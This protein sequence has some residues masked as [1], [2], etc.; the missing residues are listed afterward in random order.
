MRG[1]ELHPLF[2]QDVLNRR[3]FL[4]GSGGALGYAA[5]ASLMQPQVARAAAVT[6]PAPAVF[7]N[8]AAKAKRIIYLFQ[9]GAPS[10]MDLF[11]PKPEMAKRRGEDLPESIRQGQRL[12]TM[13]SGQK[14]F[15]V[16]PS[17]FKFAQHGD[18]GMWF[19]DLVPNI[20]R[21][22]DRWCM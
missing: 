16:A 1:K 6:G 19:S 7:P 10:Q 15:P 21:H 13:T 4:G 5:L 18:S 3:V 20:A 14:S 2:L 12:T 9:S 8:H 17:I 22:A 11:D